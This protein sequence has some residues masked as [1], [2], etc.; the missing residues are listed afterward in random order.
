VGWAPHSLELDEPS[1]PADSD[2]DLS[3]YL[4]AD[5]LPP[6]CPKCHKD[7]IHGG[8]LC[9]ACGFNLRTRKKAGRTYEPVAR[10]WES[11]MTLTTRLM[12][13][14]VGQAAQVLLGVVFLLCGES[15]WPFVV[16]WPFLTFFLCFVLGTYDRI[17]L[18]RDTRGRVKVVK[19]WRFC[20]VPCTPKETEVRGFEGV[21][22]GQWH[23][24]GFLEWLVM[25]SLLPLG[26]I[27]AIIWWYNAIH[28][29]H[30]HV[31]LAR[32]HG[33]PEV[34]VYRGR[35]EAQMID[36]CTAVCDASGLANIT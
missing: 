6:T 19:T 34:F 36:I 14:G 30:Y 23:D 7:M 29:A 2:A 1:S 12:W 27:P 11:D 3:P 21:I 17:A 31:A 24:A 32:D 10:S 5:K 8:I 13:V 28:K 9:T 25:F 26:V 16:T 22:T 33:H 15:A 4:L 20:F 18:T 35:S